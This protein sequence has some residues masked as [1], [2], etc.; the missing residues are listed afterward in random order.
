L[1]WDYRACFI[2]GNAINASAFGALLHS[3]GLEFN[4]PSVAYIHENGRVME[5]QGQPHDLA[6]FVADGSSPRPSAFA[7]LR[8]EEF[9][10]DFGFV[11]LPPLPGMDPTASLAA[12]W[13]EI[14]NRKLESMGYALEDRGTNLLELLVA[15]FQT[16]NARS[17]AFGREMNAEQF[18][19]LF[20]G[21][22]PLSELDEQVDVAIAVPTVIAQQML[23]NPRTREF[24][25]RGTHALARYLVG[26][27]D[28]F[29]SLNA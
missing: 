19:A 13:L 17:M 7:Q 14:S 2:L 21:Q 5:R 11:T 3:F 15:F 1:S 20:A 27:E 8:S 22:L 25:I 6:S 16:L 12:A 9:S 26:L 24:D 29:P 18:L 23:N 10:F 28:L 4:G